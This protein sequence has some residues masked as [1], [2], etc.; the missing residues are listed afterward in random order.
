MTADRAIFREPGLSGRPY[1]L[2]VERS[3]NLKPETLFNAWTKEFDVWFAAP[4]SVLMTGKI[5]T[6]FF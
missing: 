2:T 6:P 5:N 1:N 3:M 4:G